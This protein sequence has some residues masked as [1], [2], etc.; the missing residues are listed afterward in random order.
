MRDLP[1]IAT[2]RSTGFRKLQR[3]GRGGEEITL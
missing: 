3:L 1:V 2:T